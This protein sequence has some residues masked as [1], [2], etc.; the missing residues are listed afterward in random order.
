MGKK[1]FYVTVDTET[2]TLPFANSLCK[3]AKEKQKIA[4]AKPL[5]YDLG[6]VVTDTQ[7]NILKRR[8]YLIQ[9]IFFVPSVFNTA[10][11]KDKRPIYMQLLEDDLIQVATWNDAI[12]ELIADMEYCDMVCAYNA[13]FDFKKAIPFT[14]QYIQ[15]LYSNDYTI[16][17]EQQKKDV[18]RLSKAPTKAKTLTI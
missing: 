9:E 5:V 14:E 4:I 10:Y 6:W 3:T 11:Y 12:E 7:G 17:E 15:H 16:W 13:C 1:K 18:S 8:N 2:C